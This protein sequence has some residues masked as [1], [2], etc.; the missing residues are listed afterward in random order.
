MND[1]DKARIV[2]EFKRVKG[3]LGQ[4]LVAGLSTDD[5]Y[6]LIVSVSNIEKHCG[7]WNT[8]I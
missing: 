5:A 4:D 1:I 8:V 7:Y 3:H 2:K 6:A